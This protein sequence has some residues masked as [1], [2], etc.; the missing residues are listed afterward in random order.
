MIYWLFLL[1]SVVIA[2]FSQIL[3][4]KSATHKHDSILREY[5]NPYVII[6]YGMMVCSTILTIFAYKGIEYHHGPVVESLGYILVMLLSF[7]FFNEKISRTKLFGNALILL[8]ILI[9]YL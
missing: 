9:F 6:G 1:A 2:S 7:V 3:L 5:I 4:K 8:G